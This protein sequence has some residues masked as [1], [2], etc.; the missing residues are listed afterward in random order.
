MKGL[1]NLEIFDTEFE[2]ECSRG[3]DA[4]MF[5]QYFVN[6]LMFIDFLIKKVSIKLCCSTNN[7]DA[8]FSGVK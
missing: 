1:N 8:I 7:T 6:H 4:L 5:S 3:R 2:L